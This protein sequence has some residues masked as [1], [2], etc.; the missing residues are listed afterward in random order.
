MAT[1]ARCQPWARQAAAAA[2]ARVQD[3]AGELV[4][5]PGLL[6][7]V[8]E[9]GGGGDAAVGLAPAQQRLDVRR[10]EG[11]QRH[12]RLVH[13]QQL[14]LLDRAPQRLLEPEA[15]RGGIEQRRAVE[16]EA[17]APEFLGAEQRHVG[18]AQ[19]AFRVGGVI[20]VQARADAGAGGEHAAVDVERLLQRGDDLGGVFLHL[21]RATS[22]F[23][24]STVNS[25]PPRRA[26]R[27]CAPVAARSR[28]A[29][30]CSTRSPKL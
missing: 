17:V 15:L 14:A 18:G 23:S 22:T 10:L 29:M 19:Q 1:L 7:H 13:E 4:D 11:V 5:E 6:G 8:D 26:S 24:S 3:P 12:L 30:C 9:L 27:P 2:A 21:R 20:G 16:R 25:S 28:S